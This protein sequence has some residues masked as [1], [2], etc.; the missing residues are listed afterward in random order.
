MPGICFEDLSLGQSAELS[1]TV[2]ADLI[3]RFAEVSGDDNQVTA[4]ATVTGLDAE[5]ARATLETLCLV[6]GKTVLDGEAVVMVPRKE[7]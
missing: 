6:D 5:R 4:R 3:E 7:A 2:T 1:Y